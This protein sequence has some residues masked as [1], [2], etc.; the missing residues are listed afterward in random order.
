MTT[1]LV[2]IVLIFV[3]LA[4]GIAVQNLYRRFAARHS[5]LGPFR[6]ER[7]CGSCSSGGGCGT[8]DCAPSRRD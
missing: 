1:Y 8:R 2:T 3:I 5:G 7:G 4:G 6:E